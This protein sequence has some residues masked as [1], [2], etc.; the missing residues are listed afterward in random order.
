LI[1]LARRVGRRAV[2]VST[3]LGFLLVVGAGFNGASFLDFGQDY[4]SMLMA[5]LFG[6]SVLAYAVVLFVVPADA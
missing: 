2:T 4:S 3:V 5:T 6:L 1:I